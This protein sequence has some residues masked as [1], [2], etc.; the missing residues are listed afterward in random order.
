MITAQGELRTSL[1]TLLQVF[2]TRALLAQRRRTQLH[3]RDVVGAE[4]E[5][6]RAAAYNDAAREVQQVLQRFES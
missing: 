6:G 5:A 4:R 1:G 2:A 3:W